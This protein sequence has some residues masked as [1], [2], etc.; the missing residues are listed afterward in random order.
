MQRYSK[1]CVN[2]PTRRKFTIWKSLTLFCAKSNRHS[3]SAMIAFW[4][5]KEYN[6]FRTLVSS[7]NIKNYL[8]RIPQNSLLLKPPTR[9]LKFST[10]LVINNCW[11]F[12]FPEIRRWDGILFAPQ[13]AAL[14][15]GGKSLSKLLSYLL[16]LH[17][18]AVRL[19]M[20]SSEK[21]SR[22]LAR[23]ISSKSMRQMR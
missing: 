17:S 21:E 9:F 8:F 5:L 10:L 4:F 1:R 11:Q 12:N 15:S 13:R 22:L 16:N 6:Q 23:N 14:K 20:N 18:A 3:Y 2:T 7:Q 19:M